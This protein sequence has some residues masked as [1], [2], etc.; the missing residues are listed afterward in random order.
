MD[1]TLANVTRLPVANAIGSASQ[2]LN[3]ENNKVCHDQQKVDFAKA[4]ILGMA[5]LIQ[6][7]RQFSEEFGLPLNQV[8]PNSY[9]ALFGHRAKDFVSTLFQS[10]SLNAE[11]IK[12][13]F[14]DLTMHQVAIFSSLDGIAKEGLLQLKP[15]TIQSTGKGKVRDAHAWRIFKIY[16][17]ELAQNAN[18]RFEKIISNG[19]VKKYIQIRKSKRKS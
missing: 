16:F 12:A 18:L 11:E 1:S 9:K 5:D 6:G 19:L 8:F 10:G 15:E 2:K 4:V 14:D 17:E 3:S 13:L 7:Q